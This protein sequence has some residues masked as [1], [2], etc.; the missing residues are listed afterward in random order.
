MHLFVCVLI[1]NIYISSISSFSFF[2]EFSN[3]C[4]FFLFRRFQTQT[5]T[6]QP[7]QCLFSWKVKFCVFDFLHNSFFALFVFFCLLISTEPNIVS[8]ISTK[9]CDKKGGGWF[10]LLWFWWFFFH[11]DE[12]CYDHVVCWLKEG[13]QGT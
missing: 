8:Q 1:K 3:W 2:S 9:H 6:F 13:I 7:K 12:W 4:F 11:D 5:S 10:F